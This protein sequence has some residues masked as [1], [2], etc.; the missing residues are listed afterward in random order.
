MQDQACLTSV[1]FS[2]YS[3]SYSSSRLEASPRICSALAISGWN[4]ENETSQ[5]HLNQPFASIS[6]CRRCTGGTIRK[7]YLLRAGLFRDTESC[8]DRYIDSAKKYFSP[9]A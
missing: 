2:S 6:Q 4:T 1:S 9:N 7:P 3:Y 5:Y 8:L